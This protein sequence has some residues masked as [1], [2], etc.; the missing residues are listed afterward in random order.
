MI[1][2]DMQQDVAGTIAAPVSRPGIRDRR[3]LGLLA[4]SHVVD[5]IYLGSLPAILPFLVLERG[6]SYTS[7]AGIILAA[8]LVSSVAQPLFGILADRKSLPLLTPFS[9]LL[10]GGGIG[11]IGLISIYWLVWVAV[12]IAG[13]GVAAFHPSAARSARAA[14]GASAQGMGWFAL[15]GNIGLALGPAVATPLLLIFGLRGTP[16]LTIPAV[17]MAAILF[18][19]HLTATS[20]RTAV[21][22]RLPSTPSESVQADDWRTFRWLSAVVILRSIMYYG[23]TT[24]IALFV[25]EELGGSK[26]IASATLTVFLAV[27][28]AS[29]LLGGWIADRFG[30]LVAIRAGYLL[31][32]P[33]LLI[34]LTASSPYVAIGAA[35]LLGVGMYLPFAVQTTLG[36]EYLPNRV[37]TAL[38]VTL[39]L[40]VSAGGAFAPLFGKIADLQRLTTA[41]TLVLILPPIALLLSLRLKERP[42]TA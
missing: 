36:Q 34:I 3:A 35:G 22:R 14:A 15:G 31:I 32:I 38:G 18:R 7:A 39:G 37:G 42:P 40:A 27:G 5:D 29:T 11:L 4:I 8:T 16:F 13:I 1:V 17:V 21:T 24:L 9:L 23:I 20:D 41:L 28:A 19:L 10:V 25:I 33:A 30:R 12:A 26:S 6:Y 2:G